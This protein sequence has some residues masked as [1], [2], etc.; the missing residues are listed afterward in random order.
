MTADDRTGLGKRRIC[1]MCATQADQAA[2]FCRA[3]GQTLPKTPEKI[4]E[5]DSFAHEPLIFDTE[6]VDVLPARR[7]S[8]ATSWFQELYRHSWLSL[9]WTAVIVLIIA[10]GLLLG[11]RSTKR[12]IFM[13]EGNGQ[14]GIAGSGVSNSIT[15]AQSE[16]TSSS[17]NS[18]GLALCASVLPVSDAAQLIGVGTS[19]M[20][21]EKGTWGIV[22]AP[23]P[24]ASC[25]Y[26]YYPS[27][28]TNGDSTFLN[29]THSFQLL[30]WTGQINAVHTFR[31]FRSC[32]ITL[33]CN[34]GSPKYQEFSLQGIGA[35]A[36]WS[37]VRNATN[38]GILLVQAGAHSVFALSGQSEEWST[39]E[40]RN[41]LPLLE[42]TTLTG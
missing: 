31:V 39:T 37:V 32:N 5:F 30:V 12:G 4:E 8:I 18:T 26:D 38:D 17:L 28:A 15:P 40:A 19:T 20:R 11:W 2:M 6:P 22:K 16:S 29:P 25:N 13:P 33:K 10:V 35:K 34:S 7:S 36:I 27:P 9:R 1:P 14:I 3:C 42:Q 21:I 23:N 24:T 41:L